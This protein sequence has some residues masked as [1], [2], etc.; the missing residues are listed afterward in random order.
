MRK[1]Y[2]TCET[3]DWLMRSGAA[4][5]EWTGLL[6]D[7]WHELGDTRRERDDARRERD[8]SVR[9][10]ERLRALVPDSDDEDDSDDD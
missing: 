5:Y 9:E 1:T 2:A 4:L 10:Q 6:G 8:E 3:T 7:S